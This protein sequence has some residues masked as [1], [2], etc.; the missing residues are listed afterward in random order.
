VAVRGTAAAAVV[1]VP[2]GL[3]LW[4]PGGPLAK[5]WA[6]RA[7]TPSSLLAATRPAGGA[8]SRP[9]AAATLPSSFT[10]RVSGS[11]SE[12]EVGQGLVSVDLAMT[13]S[14]GATGKLDVH[15]LGQ[16]LPSG[17]LSMSRG[18]VTAGPPGS[19][20]QYSGAVTGLQGSRIAAVVSSG[21]SSLGLTMDVAIDQ[22]GQTLRGDVSAAPA[23]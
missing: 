4:L 15:L 8:S 19:P 5:G 23:R 20:N 16:S 22:S 9:A 2:V 21:A 3:A 14:G 17:G 11:V 6:R 12:A 18:S 1:A 10:A 7:G 13:M